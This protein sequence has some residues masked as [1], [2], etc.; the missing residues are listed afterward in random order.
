[1][2]SS[3][4]ENSIVAALDRRGRSRRARATICSASGGREQADLG[5]HAG[6]GLA[7]ADVVAVQPAVEA[8]RFGERLDAGS[9][10][11]VNRPPQVF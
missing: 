1:M 6:V 4:M 8:D 5:E 7:G 10:P 2:S 9:V 3:A 11:P